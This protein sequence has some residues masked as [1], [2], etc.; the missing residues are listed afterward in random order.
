LDQ[1]GPD[2]CHLLMAASVQGPQFDSAVAAAVLGRD[3]AEVEERLDVLERVHVVVRRVREQTFPDGTPTLRYRFVHV[4]YQ[5]A[6]YS[7]L[8]PTRK[9]AWCAA[10]ARTLAGHY[11][12]KCAVFA[13]ELALL[14]EIGRDPGPAAEYF[15]L[16]A[17]N[18]ARVFAHHE[19]VALARR[20]LALIPALPDTPRRAGSELALLVTLGMQLQVSRGYAFAEVEGVYARA[21]DLCGQVAEAPWPLLVHWGLWMYYEV[22]SQLDKSLM[23]A[24]QLLGLARAAKDTGQLLQAHLALAVTSLSLGDP[25]RTLDH[26]EQGIALYDPKRHSDQTYLYGQEPG[27]GCLAFAGVA[28]WLLGYPDRAVARCREAVALGERMGHPASHALSLYFTAMVRQYRRE[29]QA[30]RDAAEIT[31]TIASEHALAL[32][33]ANGVVMQGWARAQQGEGVSGV[34]MVRRGLVDWLATGAETHRTYFLGLLAEALGRAGR[35]EEAVG[36][37]TEAVAMMHGTGTVFHAAELHRLRGEYRLL[38]QGAG[39]DATCEADADF[40]QAIAIARRQRA[41]SLELRAAMS[42]ARLRQRQGR[43]REARPLLGEICGSFTE[44]FATA[45]LRDAKDLLEEL[46]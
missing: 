14:F 13:A 9:A 19:S 3:P 17:E 26:A 23:L 18:A 41:K 33:L 35:T 2:D 34:A 16:A 44:G 39:D 30:V 24:E 29:P 31:T 10:A 22:G 8:Q 42:L 21:R 25:A 28:L 20:G 46:G 43:A 5:N 1:L 4:L 40:N 11:G 27:V 36:V 32:W 12:E 15:R 37:L 7:A 45:D 6:L 38:L